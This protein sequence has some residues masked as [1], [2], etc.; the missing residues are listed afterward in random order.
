M[1]HIVYNT[2][3]GKRLNVDI[4]S[5]DAF[6]GQERDVIFLFT[7]RGSNCDG[8]I[9]FM[10]ELIVP[11]C[12]SDVF[13]H[14]T[15]PYISQEESCQCESPFKHAGGLGYSPACRS[16]LADKLTLHAFQVAI[17]RARFVL[18]IIGDR[19]ILSRSGVW[20]RLLADATKRGLLVKKSY[21]PH[22]IR[23]SLNVIEPLVPGA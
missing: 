4:G 5:I 2:P 8:G 1:Q 16:Q 6:Q 18:R 10:C 9:G 22:A 15:P 12:Q 20:K 23:S 17:T 11:Q 19:E 3:A 14:I 21:P 13:T 7:T